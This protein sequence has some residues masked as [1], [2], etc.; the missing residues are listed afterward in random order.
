MPG[1]WSSGCCTYGSARSGSFLA[2]PSARPAPPTPTSFKKS[3]RLIPEVTISS[4]SIVL[5][6]LPV[7]GV[8][9]DAGGE[10]RVVHVRLV[11]G[12]APAHLQRRILVHPVHLLDRAVAGLALE[13]RPHVPLVVEIGV[14]RQAVHAHPRN[15]DALG[16]VIEQL[17]DLALILRS[18]TG[19]ELV[20]VHAGRHGRDAGHG[21]ALG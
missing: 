4:R 14:I 19:H 9:V 21:R 1:I 11:A 3:R 7:A 5:T 8:T 12:N 10:L 6:S 18:R 17:G 2:Q 16:V 15:R 13:A 20:A